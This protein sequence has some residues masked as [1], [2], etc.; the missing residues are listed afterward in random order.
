MSRTHV[1]MRVCPSHLVDECPRHFAEDVG[2]HLG[3]A[4]AVL[5]DEPE[6]AGAGHRDL[7]VVHQPGGRGSRSRSNGTVRPGQS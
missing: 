3:D 5:A 4:V 1:W 7:D 2:R 6:D